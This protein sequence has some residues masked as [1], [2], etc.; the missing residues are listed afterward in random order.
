MPGNNIGSKTGKQLPILLKSEWTI[1]K[2][3]V[4]LDLSKETSLLF[5]NDLGVLMIRWS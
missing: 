4:H 2:G 3:I 5:L 1:S